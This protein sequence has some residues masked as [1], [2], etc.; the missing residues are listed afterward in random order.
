KCF[1]PK[2]LIEYFHR[3]HCHLGTQILIS[4]LREKFWILRGRRPVRNV[5]RICVRCKRYNARSVNSGSVPLPV[6]RIR[7]TNVFDVTGIGFDR[8]LFLK[9]SE[10][11]WIM[12]WIMAYALYRAVHFE[13]ASS[14][15]TELFCCFRSFIARRGWPSVVYTDNGTNFKDTLRELKYLNWTKMDLMHATSQPPTRDLPAAS[16]GQS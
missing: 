16:S 7:D 4:S 12:P 14:V 9:N 1:L 15:S 8:P 2:R 13:L 10:K 6:D 11:V 5:I 3:K